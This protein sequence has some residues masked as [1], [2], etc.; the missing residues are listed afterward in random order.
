M[1][2]SGIPMTPG[3]LVSHVAQYEAQLKRDLPGWN[4][5][6]VRMY[7]QR[8]EWNAGP[9]GAGTSVITGMSSPEELK[10]AVCVYEATLEVHLTDLRSERDACPGTGVGHDKRRSLT[11]I[12]TALEAMAARKAQDQPETP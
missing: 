11:T 1:S 10:Y 3:G 4:C 5:W 6:A 9:E 2:N 7:D 12:I 8:T